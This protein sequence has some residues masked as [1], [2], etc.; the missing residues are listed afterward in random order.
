MTPKIQN[1]L[2]REA[3]QTRLLLGNGLLKLVSLVTNKHTTVE[4]PLGAVFYIH[5]A[6]KLCT[7]D[8]LAGVDEK[9]L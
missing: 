7:E 2:I 1:P 6:S 5:S 8:Q 3:L 4:G 9:Q